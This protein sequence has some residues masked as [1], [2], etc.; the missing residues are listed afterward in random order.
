MTPPMID[1]ILRVPGPAPV[2]LDHR[3]RRRGR[4][5]GVCGNRPAT[6]AGRFGLD[7][8]CLPGRQYVCGAMPEPPQWHQPRH[9]PALPRRPGHRITDENNFLRSYSDN[10]YLWYDEIVDQD[11]GQ[12]NDPLAYFD[13]LRTFA[14]TSSGQPKDKFHFTMPTDEFFQASQGGV[15]AGYGATWTV[16]ESLPPREVAYRVHG[17]EFACNQPRANRWFVARGCWLID[18]VDMVNGNDVDTLNAGLYPESVGEIHTFEI[19][20]LG[21]QTSRTVQLTSAEITS[22]PVQNVSFIDTP[23]GRV[24]YMLF[25]DHILTAEDAL[26]DA[27]NQLNGFAH[28]RPRARRTLQRRRL[29][30]SSPASLAYMIGGPTATGGPGIR[31]PYPVERQAP[32]DRSGHG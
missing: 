14:T 19:L 28:R 5:I 3:L 2:Q 18:G 30:C 8:R 13:Q 20:D 11:P 32:G 9:K 17:T 6:T 24:G 26:V 29:S 12:F 1:R 10:T 16:I 25:N 27:V 23:T 4:R 15:S 7:T 22:A 21:T 31:D